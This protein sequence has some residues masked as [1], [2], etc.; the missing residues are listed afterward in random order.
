MAS[1]IPKI[2]NINY[3]YLIPQL[4]IILLLVYFFYLL[5][6]EYYRV[7]GISI[8]FLLSIYLKVLIPKWHR[9][10]VFLVKKGK[11]D[12]AILSFQRSYEYFKRNAWIDN[13]RA[14]TLLSS[15]RESYQEMALIN[16]IYCFEQ[17]GDTKSARKFHKLLS[18]RFPNSRFAR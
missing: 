3:Y 7:M 10:G 6:V 14:F 16:I 11:L 18:E 15:S 17:L 9:K 12:L 13:Y 4:A 2:R 1:R 5:E 8:Y